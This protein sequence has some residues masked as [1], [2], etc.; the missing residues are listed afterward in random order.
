M[1]VRSSSTSPFLPS[2]SIAP[3]RPPFPR[4][5]HCFF[6]TFFAFI[7]PPPSSHSLRFDHWC[8]WWCW[9]RYLPVCTVHHH[10]KNNLTTDDRRPA[11]R[12]GMFS[13]P[14]PHPYPILRYPDHYS[15]TLAYSCTFADLL[16]LP[17]WT[18]DASPA[19]YGSG[20]VCSHLI[21]HASP[22]PAIL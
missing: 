4:V 15:N 17:L 19:S 10:I 11:N 22:Y 14:Y 5:Y 6:G 9:N 18:L 12:F 21:F 8:C 3:S 13:K 2:P 20:G 7:P 16:S 1:S